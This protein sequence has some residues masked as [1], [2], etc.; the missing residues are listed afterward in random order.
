[1]QGA[2]TL[3]FEG[4]KQACLDSPQLPEDCELNEK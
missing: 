2:A 4:Q 3:V 1:V